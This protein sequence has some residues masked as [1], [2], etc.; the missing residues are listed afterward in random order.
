[1][2]GD[3]EEANPLPPR[4]MSTLVNQGLR[5]RQPLKFGLFCSVT[6]NGMFSSVPYG[7]PLKYVPVGQT[8]ASALPYPP[9][10]IGRTR[11]RKSPSRCA[12]SHSQRA[13]S[14]NSRFTAPPALTVS[15]PVRSGSTPI[16]A[17]LGFDRSTGLGLK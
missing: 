1:M 9:L 4:L 16:A 8:A 2:N 14:A 13:R 17:V 5:S 3:G 15:A 6:G 10:A 7:P 12:V 11:R